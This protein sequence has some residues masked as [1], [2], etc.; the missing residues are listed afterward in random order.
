MIVRNTPWLSVVIPTFNGERFLAAALTSVI[1]ENDRDIEIIIVDD[2]SSDKTEEIVKS[3]TKQFPINLQSLTHTGNWAANTNHGI[4][5]ARGEYISI[6]H[7]D[8]SWEAGRLKKIKEVLGKF[9]EANLVLH[10]AKFI[11]VSGKSLGTWRAPFSQENKL[12]SSSEIMR[13]LLVQNFIAISAPTFKRSSF[14]ELGGL[15]ATLWFTPD[16]KC[17]LQFAEEANWVYIDKVL[18]TFRVHTAAQTVSRG[19]SSEEYRHEYE[20]VLSQF[21]QSSEKRWDDSDDIRAQAQFSISLNIFLFC[22]MKGWKTNWSEVLKL[23]LRLGPRNALQYLRNSRISE[24][25]WPRMLLKLKV[26]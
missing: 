7:Q 2:G 23:A 8:D 15:D 17:W 22:L 20:Q 3:F 9:P 18:S 11:N 24:R 10:A 12:L 25:L 6:L 4:Q 26:A 19:Q 5:L 16:W 1:A 14:I 21:L 13:K